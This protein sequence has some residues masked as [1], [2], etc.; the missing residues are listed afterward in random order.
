MQCY[1]NILLPI[2]HPAEGLLFWG[3]C[4]LE[5]WPPV[6][7]EKKRCDLTTVPMPHAYVVVSRFAFYRSPF[8]KKIVIIPAPSGVTGVCS[9][10]LHCTALHAVTPHLRFVSVRAVEIEVVGSTL[11]CHTLGGW[12]WLSAP[13]FR[14]TK[15]GCRR[16]RVCVGGGT[17]AY[18][19]V[20]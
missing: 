18:V 17:E 8:C 6:L 4:A 5:A 20:S 10:A 12:C 19:H 11:Y 14:V 1:N 13:R 15:K 16:K 2:T 3:G 7:L 9:T